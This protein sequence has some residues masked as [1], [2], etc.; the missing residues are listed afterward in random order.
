MEEILPGQDISEQIL[1][2]SDQWGKLRLEEIWV[3][4]KQGTWKSVYRNL[5]INTAL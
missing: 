4:S 5:L 2:T 1:W 3:A